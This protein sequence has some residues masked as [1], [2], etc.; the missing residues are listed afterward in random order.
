MS[1][2]IR[3]EVGDFYAE[4]HEHYTESAGDDYTERAREQLEDWI[5]GFNKQVEREI[6]QQQDAMNTVNN[7]QD[8]QSSES[9]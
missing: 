1:K 6:E 7:Q 4:L 8:T 5:H 3:V 9:E 2:K